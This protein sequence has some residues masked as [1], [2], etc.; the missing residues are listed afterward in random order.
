M[1]TNTLIV[2]VCPEHFEELEEAAAFFGY[3]TVGEFIA[4][5]LAT[6]FP[7]AKTQMQ[8]LKWREYEE[9]IERAAG[10]PRKKPPSGLN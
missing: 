10:V 7:R 5:M 8:A 2:E 4:D 9:A 3:E 6:E 1:S